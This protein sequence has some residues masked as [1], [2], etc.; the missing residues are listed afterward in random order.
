MQIPDGSP[1]EEDYRGYEKRSGRNII[2]TH[3]VLSDD[4]EFK[5]LGL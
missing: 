3:R 5:D 1:A 4:L 2:G